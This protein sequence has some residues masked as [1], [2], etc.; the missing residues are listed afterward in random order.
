MFTD[1]QLN[2]IFDRTDGKCHLCWDKLKWHNYANFG[3]SGAW[4]VDHSNPKANGGTDRANNLY[5]ACIT[6]NRSKG[7]KSTKSQRR[8]H[9]Y[10]RAPKSRQ[11]RIQTWTTWTVLGAATLVTIGLIAEAQ[12]SKPNQDRSWRS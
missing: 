10:S 2:N 9:G 1:D 4:E 7:S 6:C 8:K 5:A 11:A 12:K 3:E